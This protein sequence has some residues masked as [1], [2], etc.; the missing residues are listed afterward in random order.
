MNQGKNWCFTINNP[1]DE[2]GQLLDALQDH[3][4]YM[5]CG[6]EKGAEGTP[7]VQGFCVMKV[8]ARLAKMKK[9]LPRAHLEL[10][11]GTAAQAADYCKKDGDFK[12]YGTPPKTKVEVGA[13]NAERYEEAW[14]LAKEGRLEEIPADIRFRCYRTCKEIHRDYMTRPDDLKSVCGIWIHGKAG[15]GKTTH[16]RRTYPDAYIKSRNQ[17]WDG[18]QGE[19]HVIL[20]DL[21]PYNVGLAAYLKDWADKWTFKAEV[22][23][24]YMWIR[25]TVFV[26]TSQYTIEDI[27]TDAETRDALNRR[28]KCI[29]SN[30]NNLL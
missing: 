3:V 27:W 26:V 9:L 7:H 6:H 24:S 16:A 11:R 25:P 13:M 20:D 30:K 21:G 10:A 5:V 22:K 18:Y 2:D 28:F 19:E 1:T 4:T 8:N 23:G 14:G 12:E 29:D 15:T 17:W